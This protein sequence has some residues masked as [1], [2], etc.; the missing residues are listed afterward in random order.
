M[1]ILVL[2]YILDP[3]KMTPLE[4]ECPVCLQICVHPVR[5]PCS[6][7]FCFLCVKG[8]ANR[9]KRCAMCR[10]E[11]PVD[12]LSNPELLCQQDVQKEAAMCDGYRWYYE[13]WN[14]WWQYDA[15]ASTE[16]EEKFD[17]NHLQPFEILIAGFLYVI[18]F[19]NMI[20]YRRNDP[21]RRRRIKRD[22][23]TISKK[24]VAGL[25]VDSMAANSDVIEDVTETERV[26]AD[27]V[28]DEEEDLTLQSRANVLP[29]GG[30]SDQPTQ[31]TRRHQSQ[32]TIPPTVHASQRT[33]S[34]DNNLDD[35]VTSMASVSLRNTQHCPVGSDTVDV[36]AAVP[37]GTDSVDA[38]VRRQ[39]HPDHDSSAISGRGSRSSHYD[40]AT[41]IHL[42]M[43]TRQRV[44][45]QID[46]PS[47]SHYLRTSRSNAEQDALSSD[48]YD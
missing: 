30:N 21:T 2:L 20:Q 11:I 36:T 13:G 27:G 1:L 47:P 39:L 45:T 43:S 19:E 8:V 44:Q 26:Q 17:C 14:G 4:S 25:K 38:A 42:S 22:L 12:F 37:D 40:A 16:L 41:A 5:L 31:P 7:V 29:E 46:V 24:G 35:L 9:S 32:I 23:S 10:Q 34:R 33:S 18:D 6:H 15:R 48:D 3:S 28:E